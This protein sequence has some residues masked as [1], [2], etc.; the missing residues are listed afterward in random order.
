MIFQ[1]DDANFDKLKKR[2]NIDW[3]GIWKSYGI[4]LDNKKMKLLDNKKTGQRIIVY[5]LLS[6]LIIIIVILVRT[7]K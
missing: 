2:M 1:Y 3:K 7:C 5:L 6:I 4:G